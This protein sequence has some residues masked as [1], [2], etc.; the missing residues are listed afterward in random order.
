MPCPLR[1]PSFLLEDTV[2][3]AGMAICYTL[4]ALSAASSA[5]F[6]TDK[7]YIPYVLFSLHHVSCV[8]VHK[9]SRCGSTCW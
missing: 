9:E 6:T 2:I 3:K 8:H 7:A 1:T 4:H 5:L